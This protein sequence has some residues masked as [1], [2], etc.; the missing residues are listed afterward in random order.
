MPCI[1]HTRKDGL[2]DSTHPLSLCLKMKLT[3]IRKIESICGCVRGSRCYNML[4]MEPK[5]LKFWLNVFQIYGWPSEVGARNTINL[6]E[7]V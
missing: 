2:L 7:Q 6:Q 5:K 1:W 4:G 3:T